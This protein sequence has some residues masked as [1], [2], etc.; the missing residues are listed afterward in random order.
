MKNIYAVL[1]HKKTELESLQMELQALH[2]VASLLEEE[3]T[4]EEQIAVATLALRQHESEPEKA[5]VVSAAS[6]E[7]KKWWQ[8]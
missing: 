4:L 6:S 7:S 8:L 5:L 3:G 1:Q 2:I